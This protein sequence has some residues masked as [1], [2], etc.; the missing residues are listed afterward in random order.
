MLIRVDK[1]EVITEGLVFKEKVLQITLKADKPTYQVQANC[2]CPLGS[3]VGL[4]GNSNTFFAG[5]GLVNEDASDR[6]NTYGGNVAY[7]HMLSSTVGITGDAGVYFGNNNNVDFTKIQVMAGLSLAHV[8]NT[9]TLT[10]HLLA[11]IANVNSKYG[12]TSSSSTNLAAAL[13]TD[14]IIGLNNKVGAGIRADYN[15]VFY[16]GGAAHNFRALAGI[17]FRL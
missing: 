10:P 13:G 1:A 2:E 7:T 17:Y 9:F 4:D 12:S 5:L 8:M 3:N 15:P 11:G 16:K 6:F 14:V